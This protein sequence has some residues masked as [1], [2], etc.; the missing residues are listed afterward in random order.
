MVVFVTPSRNRQSCSPE[1]QFPTT[2]KFQFFMS[3]KR[4]AMELFTDWN[5]SQIFRTYRCTEIEGFA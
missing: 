5:H 2:E 1:L 3:F 4:V